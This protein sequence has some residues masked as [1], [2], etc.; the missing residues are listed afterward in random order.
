M[1]G[2][3]RRDQVE[4][5][6]GKRNLLSRTR[7][8]LDVGKIGISREDSS[9]CKHLLRYIYSHYSIDMRRD[10]QGGAPGTCGDV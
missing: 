6:I 10:H 9:L 8:K 3:S 2:V 1:G 5:V 7:L 4:P